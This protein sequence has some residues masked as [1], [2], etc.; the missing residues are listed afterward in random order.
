MRMSHC[1]AEKRIWEETSLG[2]GIIIT[3]FLFQHRKRSK[4]DEPA[5]QR[6]DKG[7]KCRSFFL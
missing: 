2:Y 1:D 6:K 5:E 4:S 3:F 7:E